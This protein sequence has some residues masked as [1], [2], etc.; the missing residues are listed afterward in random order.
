MA[1]FRFDWAAPRQ[2]FVKRK[3]PSEEMIRAWI[4][5]S[6]RYKKD[7][8]D[9]NDW[10]TAEEFCGFIGSCLN[11]WHKE[12][13]NIFSNKTLFMKPKINYFRRNYEGPKWD[14]N[15]MD[16]LYEMYYFDEATDKDLKIFFEN[17]TGQLYEP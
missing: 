12:T 13:K 7:D 4:K 1:P 14:R 11:Y 5:Y 17:L 3:A 9:G 8:E 6:F 10:I 2:W 16:I 15:N